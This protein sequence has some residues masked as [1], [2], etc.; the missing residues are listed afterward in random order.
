MSE[1]LIKQK[2]KNLYENNPDIHLDVDIPR[3]KVYIKNA[4]A[5]ITG[6]YAHI[7][8]LEDCKTLQKYTIRYSEVMV[9][10]ITIHELS[11]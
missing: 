5:K 10:H 3:P 11:Q 8:Q 2:I 9:G 4:G 7:F 1:P 6:V